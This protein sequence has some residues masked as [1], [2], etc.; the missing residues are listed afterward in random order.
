MDNPKVREGPIKERQAGM[1]QNG[2]DTRQSKT[3]HAIEFE[4]LEDLQVRQVEWTRACEEERDV[5]RQRF[6]NALQTFKN[7]F[8]TTS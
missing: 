8:S 4:L 6:M 5:A 1:D 7:F 2:G 3:R